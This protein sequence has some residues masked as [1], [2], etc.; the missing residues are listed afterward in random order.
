MQHFIIFTVTTLAFLLACGLTYLLSRPGAW[1]RIIDHPNERSL[2]SRPTPRTG[3]LAI[4]VA[5]ATAVSVL[6]LWYGARMDLI[7][8]VAAALLL[9][10]VSLAD[11][12]FNVSV[13][14]RLGVHLLVAGIVVAIGLAPEQLSVPGAVWSWPMWLSTLISL[15]FVVWL[16]NLY[17]FMDGMDGFAGGM[18]LIGFA[19][20]GLLGWLHAQWLYAGVAWSIAAAAAGFLVWNLPP[21]RIFMGDTGSST[22]GFLAAALALWGDRVDITPLWLSILIFSPFIV[23]ATVT[24]LRRALRAEPIWQAH[25]SHY[26]QRLASAGWGHRR[27]VLWE[28]A[29]MAACALTALAAAHVGPWIQVALAA[30]WIVIYALLMVLVDRFNPFAR[31]SI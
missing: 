4:L 30:L 31:G 15:I 7:W 6:V 23:D 12:K 9:A 5:V 3:G 1:L 19:T 16:I 25:R 2:H 10:V 22:I 29:L 26:Y 20:L 28:Y 24:L 11:D 18:T 21:A 14:I 27:T 13:S 8:L 17:N